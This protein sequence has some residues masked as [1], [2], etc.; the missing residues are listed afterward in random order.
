MTDVR[1]ATAFVAILAGAALQPA[2]VDTTP[3]DFRSQTGTEDATASDALV[4]SAAGRTDADLVADCRRCLAAGGC[5]TQYD[6]CTAEPKCRA[7]IDCLLGAYCLNYSLTN[8]AHLPACLL[9]CGADAGIAGQDDPALEAY[10]PVEGCAQ[11]T[12]GTSCNVQGDP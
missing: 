8:L 11:T 3:L 1:T 5:K 10:I 12:C 9:Q 7:F 2:C 6:S 4:D